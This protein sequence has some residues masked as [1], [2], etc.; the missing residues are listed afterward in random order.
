VGLDV[1][2]IMNKRSDTD[3]LI[4]YY[5]YSNYLFSFSIISV[6]YTILQYEG[7]LSYN[8]D[9]IGMAVFAFILG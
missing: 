4:N 1:L 3:K 2:N 8:T 6:R 5:Y 9:H 7:D